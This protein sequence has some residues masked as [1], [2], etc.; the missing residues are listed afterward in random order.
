AKGVLNHKTPFFA[1][2]AAMIALGTSYF[3]RGRRA[4]ELVAAVTLGIA[5]ADLLAHELG[6][7]VPQ[8]ALAVFI[9]IG[10]GL[11]FGTSQ[12][13]VN[14]V[15]VSAVLVSTV[16]PASSHISFARAVDALVGNV[17]ALCVAAVVLPADPVR[18]LREA[19][20]PVT[21]ELA[22]TL[23]DIAYALRQRDL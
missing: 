5:A 19:A 17:I 16:T 10:L 1:P 7:G 11:F 14:Q 2:V 8:L 15:A 3:E 20:R 4:A 6:R 18:I 21:D 22:G 13:F 9:A 23:R 12:L